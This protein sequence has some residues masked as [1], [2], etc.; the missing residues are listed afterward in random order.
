MNYR[1]YT[2][3]LLAYLALVPQVTAQTAAEQTNEEAGQTHPDHLNLD[4]IVITGSP[5]GRSVGKSITSI[6]VLDGEELRERASNS[7]GE[8]LRTQPGIRATSFGAGASRPIIRGLGGD[9]IRV[10]EDGIGTFDA[11]QTSPDH[12]VPIEPA[13]AERIEVVRGAA[14]LLYGS[15]AAGGVVNVDT[16]KIP[17]A[18]P[19]NGLEGAARYAYSTVNNGNEVAAGT[20]VQLGSNFVLHAEGN[21][22]NAGDFDI[23]GLNASDQ[24]VAA[25]AG[26]AIANGEPFDPTEDFTD[27][28]VGN[29]DLETWTGA[30]GGSFVFDQ[31]GYDGFFGASFSIV[32]SNYGIPAGILTEE[33]LEGEEE[34]GE[35]GEGEEGIR[36][37]LRQLRYDVRG[38]LN[39]DLGPFKALKFRAGYGDYEHFEL[40]GAE[41]GTSFFNEEFESRL[42]L[43]GKS[44]P[45][46]GGEVD[47]AIG[48]QVRVRDFEAIG[49]EAFVPPSDQV[50]IGVFGLAEYEA[51]PFLLDTALRYEFVD[52][53][54]D[55]FI[56]EEDGIPVPI[57]EDFNNFSI[58]GGIGYSI[59][60]NLFVGISGA[61]TERA[62]SLEEFF[63]FGPH[64]ATQ[65]FEVGDPT[66]DNEVARSFEATARGSLGPLTLVVNGFVTD[67]DNFIFEQE[68]GEILD[69]LPVFQFTAVDTRF[70]GFEAELD[71]E[72]GSA[73][74]AA[75][76]KVDFSARAQAD[77]VRATSSDLNNPN[78][79][80]IPPFAL[81]GGLSAKSDTAS[82][83]V[84]VEYNAAQNDV[85]DFELPTDSFTFVNLFFSFRPFESR[86]NVS[87]DLRARNLADSEG[88]AAT[89]FLKDTTP[90]PGRDIQF[91]VRLDF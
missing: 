39:G 88:R 70:R 77:F 57:D 32:D 64:L 16:G 8:T 69:G 12:A 27:G 25:L 37:D 65:S 46:F 68:T 78:Q 79:P 22:R 86:P 42:E 67:Y 87:F 5:L 66:L 31:G 38:E 80:R 60:E 71:A 26:V 1:L 23:D 48:A 44:V 55:T 24:L 59:N 18:L 91:G 33:D 63:S 61:R 58:S 85:A 17:S 10:L 3:S 20:N 6:S 45:A 13:L 50:Q 90:L 7:I 35:E 89:S 21:F 76:G 62:P 11:A 41:I 72:I 82:L 28:F 34:E 47:T 56:A 4:E 2:V 74:I 83:R 52:N 40:E 73:N 43:I 30:V 29:S 49:A 36:I 15:S 54:T 14:S 9:R 19:E 51:G 81:L 84:E 75:L 53:S